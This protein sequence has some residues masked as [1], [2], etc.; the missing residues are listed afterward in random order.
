MAYKHTV[1]QRSYQFK[2]LKTLLAKASP[3]RSGDELAGVAA[4]DAT[5]RVAAQMALADCL[6]T[7]FLDDFLIS[8][9]SDEVTR[10]IMAQHDPQAFSKIS[11][12][13]VGDLRDWLLGQSATTEA[14]AEL[15]YAFTPEMV[16]A[17]SKIMRVQ[18]LILV[19]KKM[20]RCHQVSQYHRLR[21]V[22]IHKATAQSSNR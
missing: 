7:D 1:G 19:A 12:F 15:K 18:D 3:K 6:L 8:Y 14:I 11:G 22:F 10:L 21:R 4:R 16:A 20:P 5:E 13:T 9:D 17:V 2:D